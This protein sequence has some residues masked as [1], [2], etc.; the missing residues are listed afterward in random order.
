M[1]KNNSGITLLQR[2]DAFD[3]FSV[4]VLT[5]FNVISLVYSVKI[6]N[7]LYAL[8]VLGSLAL[9]FLPYVFEYFLS[10]SVSRD[11]KIAYWFLVVGGPVLGNVYRFYHYIR[12]WD[13]LLHMLSGFLVAAFGYALPDFLLKEKPGKAFKC[14]FAV[15]ISVA[16]GGLWEIY[17]FIL[18]VL[19]QL[20]MQND[21]VITGF[22]SYMLGDVPGT[23]GSIENIENVSINGEPFEKGYIDIGLIDTMK[24]MIQCL[25]GSA[26]CAVSAAFQKPDSRFFTIRAV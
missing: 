20:D 25:T 6:K 7:A 9:V 8:S 11:L 23:I 24:D 17:E 19:F 15:S 26:V 3:R 22:S 1:V 2:S 18:D 5:A 13:K 16:I 10:C 12:P 21:T 4:S 14:I